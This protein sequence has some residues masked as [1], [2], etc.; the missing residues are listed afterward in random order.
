LSGSEIR[1]WLLLRDL[2]SKKTMTA[3]P[4][5]ADLVQAGKIRLALFLPQ[6]ATDPSNGKLRGIGIG[7]VAIEFANALAARLSVSLAVVEHPTPP[8]ALECIKSG[9]CDLGMLG[10]EPSRLGEVD[11]SPPVVQFDYTYLVPAAS[12]L[13]SVAEVDRAGTRIAVVRGHASTLAL[14]RLVKHAELIGFDVPDDAFALLNA[15]NADVFAAPREV[16]LDYSAA[17][18]GSRV[19]DDSY[20]VNKVG[21]AIRKG[22]AARLA[23]ISA[24][25]E[26]AKASGLVDQ[27]I[28]RGGLRGFRVA[29]PAS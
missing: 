17:L 19:F 7:Y 9:A 23:F 16:L 27:I 25:A 24:F 2:E 28:K 26:E 8:K 18:A 5:V 29:P 4:Q 1:Y 3:N 22:Q 20:G 12:A 6:Y 14:G 15:G 13:R 11:F 10:I 21:I